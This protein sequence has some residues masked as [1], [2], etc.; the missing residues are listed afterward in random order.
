[1]TEDSMPSGMWRRV[2]A[3][4]A[5][6]SLTL[7]PCHFISRP[8]YIS[9]LKEEAASSSET[10]VPEYMALQTKTHQWRCSEYLNWLTGN[11][12][13]EKRWKNAGQLKQRKSVVQCIVSSD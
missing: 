1:V 10:F 13:I 4:S 6:H 11:K 9:N 3:G 8:N 12:I 2:V 5:S 7:H